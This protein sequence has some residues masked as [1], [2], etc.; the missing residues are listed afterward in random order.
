MEL[1]Q[2]G[3]ASRLLWFCSFADPS[4]SLVANL[5]DVTDREIDRLSDSVLKRL[6][7]DP[8][9]VPDGGGPG[10]LPLAE[11]SNVQAV[12]LARDDCRL[13]YLTGAAPVVY[14]IPVWLH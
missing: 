14:G 11:V 5:W 9:H 12:N 10:L 1:C 4:P 7:L 3:M 6:H 13:K 2:G 8:A